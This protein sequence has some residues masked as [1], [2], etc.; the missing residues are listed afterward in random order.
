MIKYKPERA[1]DY[2]QVFDSSHV[3]CLQVAGYYFLP[4]NFP[5]SYCKIPVG[6]HL[7]IMFEFPGK[8]GL[9]EQT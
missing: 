9:L 8:R 7:Q 3:L 6:G 1:D 2:S 5:V 4:V